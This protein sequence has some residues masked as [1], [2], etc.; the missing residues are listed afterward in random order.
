MLL[1]TFGELACA[2]VRSWVQ[3]K[4]SLGKVKRLKHIIA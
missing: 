4:T 3:L 1:M 2:T